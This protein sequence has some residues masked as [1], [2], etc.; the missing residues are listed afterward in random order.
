MGLGERV[1]SSIECESRI[2]AIDPMNV[3][4]NPAS[5][6]KLI[7]RYN[8]SKCGKVIGKYGKSGKCLSCSQLKVQDRPSKE[9]LQEEIEKLGYCA[10][11][12]KYGVSDK[13]VKKWIQ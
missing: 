10:V 12:R 6:T 5:E 11:C 2:S 4:S 1:E 8:C 9:I 7:K 3:G 13:S